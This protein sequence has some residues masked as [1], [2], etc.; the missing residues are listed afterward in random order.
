[1]STPKTNDY[2]SL[3]IAAVIVAILFLNR[4]N[5]R[6]DDRVEPTDDVAAVAEQS[7]RDY[8]DSLAA[9]YEQAANE[10]RDGSWL[11]EQSRQARLKA[12]RP[13]NEAMEREF[14]PERL[15][16]AAQGVRRAIQ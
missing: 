6:Q 1:M 3:A 13:L 15:R 2:T 14:T 7:V 8:A 12:V 16:Q 10:Q 4:D 5:G 9:V 11:N